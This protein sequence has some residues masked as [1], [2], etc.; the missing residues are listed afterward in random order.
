MKKLLLFAVLL[1]PIFCFGQKQNKDDIIKNWLDTGYFKIDD[2]NIVVS[3]VINDVQGTKDEIYVRIE[4]FF[5]RTY[6]DA[7]SV[8]QTDN[9]QS[10]TIIGKG[11]F[12]LNYMTYSCFHVLRVDIKE[13]KVRIICSADVMNTHSIHYP[14]SSADDY[15][16]VDYYPITN[17][18]KFIPK[19]SQ[20]EAFIRLIKIMH[21]TIDTVEK[22]I[23]EGAIKGEN[24]NW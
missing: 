2:D 1:I 20:A 24:D 3:K 17:K 4:N 14:S 21:T 15:K 10:G 11:L 12:M 22:T 8:I 23:K 9:K 6:N 5:T 19:S 13:N 18:G 7:N 16:I